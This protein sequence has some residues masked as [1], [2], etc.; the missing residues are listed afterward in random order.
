MKLTKRL[1]NF[2]NKIQATDK[3]NIYSEYNNS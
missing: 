1:E 3:I 2:M